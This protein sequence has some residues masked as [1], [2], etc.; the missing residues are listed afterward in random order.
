M[1]AYL[2]LDS[3]FEQNTSSSWSVDN[4]RTMRSKGLGDASPTSGI[5][6][7]GITMPRLRLAKGH[8][9]SHIQG[10]VICRKVFH[11]QI[12]IADCRFSHKM[13]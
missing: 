2:F 10:R 6:I 7:Y 4:C 13:V 11:E 1:S 5:V 12:W 3:E 8:Y 9:P